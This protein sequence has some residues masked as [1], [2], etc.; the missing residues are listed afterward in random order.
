MSIEMIGIAIWATV[1][2]AGWWWIL[3]L[4]REVHKDPCPRVYNG[5]DCLENKCNHHSRTWALMGIDK[6]E[7][8][9]GQPYRGAW[10]D[11]LKKD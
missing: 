9:Y 11:P 5:Y 2:I 1:H 10:N 8:R 6:D 7:L 4:A 3:R